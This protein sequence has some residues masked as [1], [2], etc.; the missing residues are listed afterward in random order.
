MVTMPS[1]TRAHKALLLLAPLYA[2]ICRLAYTHIAARGNTLYVIMVSVLSFLYLVEA[3]IAVLSL[4]VSP[5]IR[6]LADLV[7]VLTYSIYSLSVLKQATTPSL[8]A[9]MTATLFVAGFSSSL[10]GVVDAG[11]MLF[12][13]TRSRRRPQPFIRV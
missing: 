1:L 5:A 12:A 11:K 10:Y 4:V 3:A 8:Q 9:I 2:V 6:T 7:I 13:S